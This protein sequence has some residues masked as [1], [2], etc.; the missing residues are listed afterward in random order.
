M[1]FKGTPPS[2]K[3]TVMSTKKWT[4]ENIAD[5]S[6]KTVLV[7]GGNSGIGLEAAR[8]L[9]LKNANVILTAR[10]EAKG[11]SAVKMIKS[12]LPN[13]KVTWMELDL[14]DL[15]S[16]RRFSDAFHSKYKQLDML[17]N[18]AGVMCPP[19]PRPPRY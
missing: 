16:V 6:G 15:D 5:Q 8:V 13:A 9:S 12:V 14:A 1:T 19:S 10:S 2:I 11:L 18:N 3:N 4:I 7:T 17:L